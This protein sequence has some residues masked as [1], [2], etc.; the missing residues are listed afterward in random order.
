MTDFGDFDLA[1]R[2]AALP[3]R[4]T[5]D[6]LPRAVEY[7]IDGLRVKVASLADII[8]SKEVGQPAKDR[9]TLPVLKAL[10]DEI[11]AERESRGEGAS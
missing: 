8:A 1:L 6:L 7:D 10:E 2:P 4:V 3:R 9:A 5:A 11:A